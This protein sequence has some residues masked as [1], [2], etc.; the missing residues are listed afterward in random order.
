MHQKVVESF[1][2]RDSAPR[3]LSAPARKCLGG[4]TNF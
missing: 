1:T 2:K 4:P 3:N